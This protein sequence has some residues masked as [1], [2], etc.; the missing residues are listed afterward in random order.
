MKITKA[1]LKQL[2]DTKSWK[3]GEGYHRNGNVVS[4]LEDKDIIIGKVSGT[5]DYKV[6]LWVEDGELDGT[7]TCPMGEAGVFCKHCVAVGLTHLEGQVKPARCKEPSKTNKAEDQPVVTIDDVRSY[8]S[9]QKTDMLVELIVGQMIE[10]DNLRRRLM[11]KAAR[12]RQKEPDIKAMRKLIAE[13]ADTRGFVDYHSAY[14]FSRGIHEAIDSLEELLSEGY[15]GEVIELT[16]YALARV[17]KALGEMD[18][19]NGYMNDVLEQ[20]QD[21]HH[22]ACVKARPDPEVLAKRLFEWELATDWDTFYEAAQTYADVLGEKGLAVYRRL[23]ETEWEKIPQLKPGK[24]EKDYYGRRFRLTSIMETL[25]CAEGDTEALVAV[26]RKDLSCAYRF[27]EI[28]QVYKDGGKTDRALEWAE[29]GLQTFPENVDSRLREFLANEY[30]RRRRHSETMQLIWANFTDNPG[31]EKY[32]ALKEHAERIKEWSKWRQQALE[33][34]RGLIADA[35]RGKSPTGKYWLDVREHSMLVEIFIWEQDIEAAWREAQTGGCN[36]YFWMELARLREKEHPADAV[37][38]YRTQVEPIVQRTNNQAYI[39]AIRLIKKVG[40]LMKQLGQ[41]K[42]FAEYVS[43]LRI[44][45]GAKRSF[46]KLLNRI[47]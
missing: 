20:L 32:K 19:S 35:K 14:D 10:D 24:M 28:A 31:L 22:K 44:K 29:K 21:I 26:K 34:I 40:G 2:T 5:R 3:R 8:L 7:C 30:H 27:L 16:E 12:Y 25:A 11:I 33:H 36:E 17:E 45:Y 39:E 9:E 43:S 1:Q 38:V 13:A 18:D 41:D 4:L 6:K 47:R 46:I 37:E 15:A 42:E 23:A